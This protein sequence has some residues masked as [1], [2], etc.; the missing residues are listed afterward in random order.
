MGVVTEESGIHGRY[1]VKLFCLES[2]QDMAKARSEMGATN[3]EGGNRE[4]GDRPAVRF[5]GSNPDLDRGW[6]NMAPSSFAAIWK[7]RWREPECAGRGGV[8]ERSLKFPKEAVTNGRR[9]EDGGWEG[10]KLGAAAGLGAGAGGHMG[11]EEILGP[12]GMTGKGRRDPGD[13]Y[14]QMGKAWECA[15]EWSRCVTV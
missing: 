15:L 13:R 5:S 6:Q 14:G 11:C 1:I 3:R 12:D 8:A 7:D 2:G 9:T 10:K 4:F